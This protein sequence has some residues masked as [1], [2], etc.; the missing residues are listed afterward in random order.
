MAGNAFLRSTG[1][2]LKPQTFDLNTEESFIVGRDSKANITIKDDENISENQ[3]I[4]RYC[5]DWMCWTLED[6]K[7]KI[8]TYLNEYKVFHNDRWDLNDGGT[9]LCTYY[10]MGFYHLLVTWRID[11]HSM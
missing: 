4:V 9:Y 5:T 6:C 3:F 1:S 8:G 7:S 2:R 11:G 10:I